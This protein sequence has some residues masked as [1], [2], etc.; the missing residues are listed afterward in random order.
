MQA[1][2]RVALSLGIHVKNIHPIDLGDVSM[3]LDIAH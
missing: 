2:D 1:E 3:D